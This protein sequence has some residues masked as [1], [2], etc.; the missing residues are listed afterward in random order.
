MNGLMRLPVFLFVAALLA[1]AAVVG[2]AFANDNSGK[3]SQDSG[4]SETGHPSGDQNGGD[5]AGGGH[6][7]PEPSEGGDQSDELPKAEK[8]EQGKHLNAELEHGVVLVRMPGVHRTLPLHD[9]ASLPVG[10]VVDARHGAVTFVTVPN[11]DGQPQ[12]ATFSGSVFQ[13]RQPH[14]V[15]YTELRLRGGDFS[16]CS[17]RPA[18]RR[19]AFGRSFLPLAVMSRRR[20]RSRRTVRRLWGSGHGHFRTRGRNGAATVRGTIW[21]TADRCDGTLVRVKRGLVDV[22]DFARHKNVSVPAGHRYLARGRR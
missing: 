21:M 1:L 19:S 15:R 17:S 6:Q 7:T 18:A 13:V 14:G 12:E 11:A 8:P 16:S 3:S 22:R 2:P 9:L 5:P 20:G 10:A 4:R